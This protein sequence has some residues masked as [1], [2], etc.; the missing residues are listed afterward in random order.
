MYINNNNDFCEELLFKW[1]LN[2][3]SRFK[4]FNFNTQLE[5]FYAQKTDLKFVHIF[6]INY[7]SSGPQND[8]TVAQFSLK[9]LNRI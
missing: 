1:L 3:V 9:Y 7:K 4:F 6:W 5:N 8:K 2:R